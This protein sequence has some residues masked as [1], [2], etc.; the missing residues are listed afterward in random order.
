MLECAFA[1][2]RNHAEEHESSRYVGF[3][4]AFETREK[5][6]VDLSGFGIAMPVKK[7]RVSELRVYIGRRSGP[8]DGSRSARIAFFFKEASLG[9][10]TRLCVEKRTEGCCYKY[11]NEAPHDYPQTAG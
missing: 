9:Y 3:P 4:G 11:G 1:I 6:L 10:F 7:L 8:Q 2:V 5:A